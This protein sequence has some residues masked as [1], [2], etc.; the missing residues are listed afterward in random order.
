MT[1]VSWPAVRR[2][3]KA[4]RAAL[5]ALDDYYHGRLS[6]PS[7]TITLAQLELNEAMIALKKK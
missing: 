4:R 2:V 7:T 6:N 1:K 3:A 5:A